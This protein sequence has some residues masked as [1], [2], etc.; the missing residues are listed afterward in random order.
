MLE[1]VNVATMQTASRNIFCEATLALEAGVVEGLRSRI[2]G[3]VL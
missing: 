3:D 1:I 2:V